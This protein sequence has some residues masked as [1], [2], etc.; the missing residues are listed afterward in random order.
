LANPSENP[1]VV[2]FSPRSARLF[3]TQARRAGLADRL[4]NAVALCLSNDVATALRRAQWLEVRIAETRDADAM[5][6]LVGETAERNG[7]TGAPR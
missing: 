6:R 7:R 4:K 3:L 2:F 5:L 1:A